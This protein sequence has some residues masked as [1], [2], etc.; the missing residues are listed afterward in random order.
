M[1]GQTEIAEVFRQICRDRRIGVTHQRQVI[2]QVIISSTDHPSP[3][4]V[5]DRVR[6]QIPSVSLA[7][8]YKCLHT[9]LD[10]G[11]IKEASLHHGS[12]RLDPKLEHHHHLLCRVCGLMIDVGQ[13]EIGP[14]PIPSNLSRNFRVDAAQVDFIGICGQC[15]K[16]PSRGLSKS[17]I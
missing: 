4:I 12:V 8:V 15:N 3:E 13:S 11:I 1:P 9:F 16:T 10:A 14:V 5:F 17:R 2:Y 7:T 6:R